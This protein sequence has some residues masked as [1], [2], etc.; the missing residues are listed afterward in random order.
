M[1]LW[2]CGIMLNKIEK[3]IQGLADEQDNITNKASDYYA[4]RFA[5]SISALLLLFIIFL[6]FY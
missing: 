3:E 2:S 6:I 1:K 5:C 4:S